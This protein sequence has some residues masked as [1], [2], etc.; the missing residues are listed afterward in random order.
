[1]IR[2]EIYKRQARPKIEPVF[3]KISLWN[4]IQ[5]FSFLFGNDKTWDPVFGDIYL[6]M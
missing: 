4:R 6:K 1:L 3:F 2:G 5:F